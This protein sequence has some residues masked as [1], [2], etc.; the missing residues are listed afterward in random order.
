MD[1][2][3]IADMDASFYQH[4]AEELRL[5]VEEFLGVGLTA[6]DVAPTRVWLLWDCDVLVGCFHS[7]AAANEAR[8]DVQHRLLCEYGGDTELLETVTV[9]TA[10]IPFSVI[11]DPDPRS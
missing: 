8:A 5:I 3:P 7:E 11:I 4:Y 2:T 1:K 10:L 6:R 9:T